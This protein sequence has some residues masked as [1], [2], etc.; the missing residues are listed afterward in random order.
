MVELIVARV[1][2]G[3]A[4][5]GELEPQPQGTSGTTEGLTG[6]GTSYGGSDFD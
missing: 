5:S 1:E 2:K 3:F 6:S 4:G